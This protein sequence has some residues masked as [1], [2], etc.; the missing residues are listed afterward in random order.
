MLKHNIPCQD[1]LIVRCEDIDHYLY[2]CLIYKSCAICGKLAELHHE[3]TVGV[4]GYR[5]SINHLG[6]KGIALCREH[7]SI[8]EN[9]GKIE[10]YNKFHIYGVKIDEAICEKYNLP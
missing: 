3:D 4:R 6:L 1:S 7:H 8:C 9:M 2:S 5:K 10:F